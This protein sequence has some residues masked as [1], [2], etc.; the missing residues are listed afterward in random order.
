MDFSHRLFQLIAQKNVI[1]AQPYMAILRTNTMS[2]ATDIVIQFRGEPKLMKV[3]EGGY[4]MK[5]FEFSKAGDAFGNSKSFKLNT[6]IHRDGRCINTDLDIERVIKRRFV[7][8][9]TDK[10]IYKPGDE[11]QFRVIL[12]DHE[13]K[14]ISFN[15][16]DIQLIPPKGDP[17]QVPAHL[18]ANQNGLFKDKYKL[19]D[20]PVLGVWKINATIDGRVSALKTFKVE[21]YQLPLY[22]LYVN[23]PPKISLTNGKIPIMIEAKYSFGGFVAGSATVKFFKDNIEINR[24]QM[25]FQTDWNF[26]FDIKYDLYIHQLSYNPTPYRI[27]I[28]FTDSNGIETKTKEI[29]INLYSQRECSIIVKHLP[30]MWNEIEDYTFDVIVEDFDGNIVLNSIEKVTAKMRQELG[31][32]SGKTILVAETI[33]H[34]IA[35]LTF[36]NLTFT[37]SKTINITYQNCK[38]DNLKIS[39]NQ[40]L[41]ILHVKH[42]PKS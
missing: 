8:I 42:S 26:D 32:S 38:L 11:I 31:S 9:Q 10:T 20:E 1:D 30:Q 36:Q 24:K 23:A 37:G 12:L 39:A 35:S 16:L 13:L 28:T 33:K 14:P 2:K 3:I 22:E 25:S 7:F 29:P 17:I 4:D 19:L 15:R 6:I 21:K 27:H 18:K 40:L 41:D 34:G 5:L